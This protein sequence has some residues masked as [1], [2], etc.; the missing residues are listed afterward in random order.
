MP[1]SLNDDEGEVGNQPAGAGVVMGMGGDGGGGG[2]GAGQQVW[3]TRD[4]PDGKQ[5]VIML[6]PEQVSQL[7]KLQAM[8]NDPSLSQQDVLQVQEYI[9]HQIVST[10]SVDAA[11]IPLSYHASV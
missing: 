9:M 6:S 3:V 5:D 1:P 10:P 7:Q 2:V 4:G 8:T 11:G